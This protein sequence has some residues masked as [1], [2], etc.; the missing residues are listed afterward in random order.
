MVEIDLQNAWRSIWH[1]E[2]VSEALPLFSSLP[3][4]V[5]TL[6]HRKESLTHSWPS[7]NSLKESQGEAPQP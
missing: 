5:L 4:L 3:A 7:E 2:G 6:D 1:I